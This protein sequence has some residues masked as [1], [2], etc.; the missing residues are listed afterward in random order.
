[1]SDGEGEDP[2]RTSPR[3][4]YVDQLD[5]ATFTAFAQSQAIVFRENVARQHIEVAVV[6]L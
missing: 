4:A 2:D 6:L 3:L 5:T 1:M